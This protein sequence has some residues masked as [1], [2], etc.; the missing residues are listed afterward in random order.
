MVERF[1]SWLAYESDSHERV[2]ESLHSVPERRRGEP[3]YERSVS[4]FAHILVCRRL[5]L[6]R[7]GI[8]P[9]GPREMFPA[10]VALERLAAWSAEIDAKWSAYLDTLDDAALTRSFEYSSI[11]GDRYRNTIGE[12][13]TQLFGHSWYHRGQIAMLVRDCGGTPAVTDFVYYSREAI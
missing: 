3:A 5:W 9:D 6:H 8:E 12:I 4:I 7:L 2:L 13:L 10:S 11:E 1:R